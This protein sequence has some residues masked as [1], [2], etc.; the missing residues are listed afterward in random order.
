MTLYKIKDYSSQQFFYIKNFCKLDLEKLSPRKQ[1]IYC[2]FLHFDALKHRLEVQWGVTAGTGERAL[3]YSPVK[4]HLY[5]CLKIHLH[6]YW[7]I[8]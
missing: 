7:F 2:C 8:V 1:S 3:Q 5:T 6:T 4:T